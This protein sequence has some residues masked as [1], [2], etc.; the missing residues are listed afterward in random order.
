MI[1]ADNDD[2]SIAGHMDTIVPEMLCSV[3]KVLHILFEN[4]D[5]IMLDLVV[6]PELNKLANCKSL[7]D[8]KEVTGEGR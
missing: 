3:A 5:K 2:I 4:E 6:L 7:D 1:I 8:L